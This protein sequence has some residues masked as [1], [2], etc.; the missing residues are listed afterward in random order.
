[1]TAAK[2]LIAVEG[3]NQKDDHAKLQ[4]DGN[5]FAAML[6]H[7]RAEGNLENYAESGSGND[8]ARIVE[9]AD[10]AR[11]GSGKKTGKKKRRG[12]NRNSRNR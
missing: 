9:E 1:M 6:E 12:R 4:Q 8:P 2:A 3:Q 7:L 11:Q 5:R 10:G